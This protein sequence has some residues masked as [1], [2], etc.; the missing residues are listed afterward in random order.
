MN[1]KQIQRLFALNFSTFRRYQGCF[2]LNELVEILRA[3]KKQARGLYISNSA[4]E[5]EAGKHWIFVYYDDVKC[6][7]FDS[8]AK[9]P[10]HY[11]TELSSLLPYS[12]ETVP[13]PIQ[14]SGTSDLCGFYCL[15][16]GV[17]LCRGYSLSQLLRP[18]EL[19][20][21][22]FDHND[23]IVSRFMFELPY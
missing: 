6:I 23:E 21:R 10:D 4:R 3:H 2:Y 7:F 17:L 14:N 19:A 9:H 15:Y 20:T 11:D 22:N 5:G 16:A 18:F 12:Y 8:L 13:H 1:S